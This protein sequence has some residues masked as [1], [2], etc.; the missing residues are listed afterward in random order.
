MKVFHVVFSDPIG[1]SFIAYLEPPE[2]TQN[3]PE[4]NLKSWVEETNLDDLVK[5]F[6]EH[7]IMTREMGGDA[8]SNC[9]LDIRKA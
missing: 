6:T 2:L 9:T 7:V 3:S 5:R 4:L 1:P 8:S